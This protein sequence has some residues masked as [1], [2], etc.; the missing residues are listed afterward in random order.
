VPKGAEIVDHPTKA[1]FIVTYLANPEY[2]ARGYA[3]TSM[4]AD[5][6]SNHDNVLDVFRFLEQEVE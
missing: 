3:C 1:R 2:G 4:M 6:L 5:H